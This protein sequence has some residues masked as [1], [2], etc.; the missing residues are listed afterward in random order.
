MIYSF[1]LDGAVRKNQN[2]NKTESKDSNLKLQRLDCLRFLF[3][4]FIIGEKQWNIPQVS[5]SENMLRTRESCRPCGIWEIHLCLSQLAFSFHK[6]APRGLHFR[7][8]GNIMYNT[9]YML[10]PPDNWRIISYNNKGEKTSFTIKRA[11]LRIE[12]FMGHRRRTE[13]GNVYIPHQKLRIGSGALCA[14]K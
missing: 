7:Y 9:A 13:K 3:D 5:L 4:R 14:Q 8:M 12:E 2:Q 11:S 6:L 1:N 10:T